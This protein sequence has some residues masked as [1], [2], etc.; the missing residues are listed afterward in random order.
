MKKHLLIQSSPLSCLTLLVFIGIMSGSCKKQNS[1]LH[2]YFQYPP[3]SAK[4]WVFWYWMHAGVSREGITADLEAMKEAGLGGA[5]LMSIKGVTDPP[6]YEPPVEQLSPFWWAMVSHALNEADRLGLELAMHASDGFALAG[7][8]WIS[9]EMSMQKLVWKE[10]HIKGGRQYDD[11]LPR[12]QTN[13]GYYR[14]VAILA[15]PVPEGADIST[16][17]VTPRI[18]TSKPGVDARFL[19]DENNE[20]IFRSDKPCWIQYAFDKPF[21]CRS[22]KISTRGNNYQ[23]QRL[24]IKVSDDGETF[25]SVGRLESPRHGWQDSDADVTH[26]IPATTAKYFRFVYNKE[27]S[28]PG[29]EDLD[30]AK[31]KPVLRIC[32]IELSGAPRLHHYEGKTAAVWRISPRTTSGQVPDEFCVPV[33]QIVNITE[34][35]NSNGR[36][37]WNVPDGHWTVLRLGHTSTG[38]T[39]VTGG[40]G[41]GLECDKFNPEAA[42]IQFD[43]WFGEAV[44]VA[45]PELA[46]RVLRILHTDSWECG[47]QNWS[48]V[49]R[50]EF[51]KRRGY[52]LLPY[53]PAMT[54]VPVQCADISER[55][56]HDVRQT[57]AEL[58]VDNFFNTMAELAHANGCIFS[59]ECVA[60]TMTSDGML[61]YREVDLPMGEF[62]FRS[63]T[64]D[65]PND[66]LDAISGAHIYG[67]SVIQAE[68]FTQLRMAWDEHPAMLKVLADRNY[69]LGINR[70]VYHVF[71]HNPWLDRK[72]GMTLD[73]VGL[74]FQRDQTWWGPGR[75]WTDYIQRCQAL[76]QYG[77]PV[78]DIAVFTGEE[79]PR[80]AILPD[81]LVPSLPG[82]FG[83]E[84][85]ESER[86]RL[87]NKGE[88]LREMPGGVKHSANMADPGDWIDPLRGYK[89]DSFNRDALLQYAKVRNGRIVL[90]GGASYGLL[91]IP[92]QRKMSPNSDLMTPEVAVKLL[93][94]VKAGATLIIN[95]RPIRSPGLNNFPDCDKIL[96]EVI[97]ELWGKAVAGQI[98]KS[99]EEFVIRH[100]GKGRVITGPFRGN[101]FEALGIEPD[102]IVRDSSG[103]Y[104][105]DIAWTHRTAPGADIYFISN[106]RNVKRTVNVSLRVAGQLPEIFD[107]L[108]GETCYVKSWQFKDVRTELPLQMF[109]GG[110]VFIVLSKPTVKKYANEGRNWLEYKTIKSLNGP[111]QVKFDEDFGGPADTIVFR[112]LTDWSTHSEPG[113]KYYS[114]T[115]TYSQTFNW[116]NTN[117]EQYRIWLDLGQVA[118][119]AEVRVNDIYCGAAWITPHRVEITSALQKGENKLVIEVTNTWANRL[120][121]DRKIPEDERITWT[122]APYRL[123]DQPL[124]KSGLLGP[125]TIIQE[126]K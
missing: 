86:Q 54:G 39:N 19:A 79:T 81:R 8:P 42:R 9:P 87:A 18:T 89:Y 126:L 80:R 65:K 68:A 26:A 14:D 78:V 61:H 32:S 20:K 34:Y 88:P 75:E 64:H 25:R 12:P 107:P 85:I 109:P 15:F 93:E 112:R 115:A 95:E 69:A 76:F 118:N 22:V 52:D 4:P 125:V 70:L 101:S 13:E 56:L 7:G 116:S 99:P 17:T 5:Y 94:L 71:T 106:Q 92:G 77:R 96:G 119:I 103:S 28:E 50:D 105:E 74:Y 24:L 10:I 98:N 100:I 63:P 108:T 2:F 33:D 121:G 29:A 110:S 51:Q 114:G 111:W 83:N 90:P 66:I 49:F 104:A 97:D 91:V 35:Y 3:E 48:P 16:R 123:E 60:P 37:V 44:R 46:G 102:F 117:N 82:I 41:R 21:T 58:V 55:F 11:T 38:H 27:G 67:K 23:A 30:A 47:S 53:L 1:D 31:W 6:V 40:A 62:W 124:L 59:A 113:I 122:T 120:T 73:G 36:L 84:V 45:G 72:P 57:I 43:N